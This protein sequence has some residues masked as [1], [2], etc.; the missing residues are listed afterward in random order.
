MKAWKWIG[1]LLVAGALVHGLCGCESGGSQEEIA[2][3]GDSG[4]RVNNEMYESAAVF[5]DNQSIGTV[6]GLSSRYWD[7][8]AGR[9]WL[10]V[11]PNRA[12]YD[13][14]PGA[15]VTVRFHGA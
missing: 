1:G 10:Q 9:H 4:L 12:E 14:R 3:T 11:G 15:I 7:V 8:P 2:I 6:A 13:F 5:F